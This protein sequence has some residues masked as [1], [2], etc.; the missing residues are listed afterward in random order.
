MFFKVIVFK[1]CKFHRKTSVFESYLMNLQVLRT[2]T[3]LKRDSNTGFLLLIL[4]IIQEYLFCVEDQWTAG[5]ET[6]SAPF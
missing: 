6:P 1:A 2:A 5:S 4:R 3:L